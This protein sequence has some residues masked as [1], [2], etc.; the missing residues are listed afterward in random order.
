MEKPAAWR[1]TEACGEL[2]AESP[3][4]TRQLVTSRQEVYEAERVILA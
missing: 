4:V 1:R 3:V 2:T